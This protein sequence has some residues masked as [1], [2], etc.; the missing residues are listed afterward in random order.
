M[1]DRKLADLS[2]AADDI[3]RSNIQIGARLTPA[4]P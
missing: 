3:Y 1:R 2:D 4:S